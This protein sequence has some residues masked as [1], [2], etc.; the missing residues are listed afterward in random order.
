[1]KGANGVEYAS[2]GTRGGLTFSIAAG[3]EEGD[4]VTLTAPET[5]GRGAAGAPLCG[6]FV[7]LERDRLGTVMHQDMITVPANPALTT[8]F[9]LLVVD[10]TGAANE[11]VGGRPGM[12]ILIR[13]GL[14]VIDLG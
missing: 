11:G 6:K 12:V 1:M 13:D 3:T 14:A 5:M 7:K 8:G 9:K 2:N 4:A 10:G